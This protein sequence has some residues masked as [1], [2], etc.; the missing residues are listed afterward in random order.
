MVRKNEGRGPNGRGSIYESPKGS[1]VWWAQLPPDD[2][3][4]RPKRRAGSEREA[5]QKLAELEKERAKGID[6][7]EPDETLKQYLNS[8]L[9]LRVK[10]KV[11][12]STFET[13][14]WLAEHYIIPLIGGIR[15][16][17]LKAD[18]IQKLLNDLLEQGRARGTV[19]QV[20][21]FLI[22]ALNTA[23]TT[24]RPITTNP[25]KATA[26]AATDDDDEGDLQ[27]FTENEANRLLAAVLGHRLYLLYLLAL[28][29]GL[30]Q[31]E[32]IGLR[33]S[34]VDLQKRTIQIRSQIH[35]RKRQIRR[36]APKGKSRR[37]IVIDA[38]TA[39]LLARHARAQ[40]DERTFVIDHGGEWHDHGLLFPSQCGTPL[41]AHALRA[42]Y[43]KA[44]EQAKLP[45]L[46]FHAL[47][48]TAACLMLENGVPLADVSEILGHSSPAITA[49][50]YLHGS[51]GGK[52]AAAETMA[53]V[54]G[55]AL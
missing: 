15:L 20:R 27:R 52:Q 34:D 45:A 53:R 30:R 16:R 40:Q 8:Y 24:G 46:T 1:G 9:E 35:R 12:L 26:V 31:A 44:L 38:T 2:F 42:H 7:G 43:Q 39:T 22:A 37:T 14:Q 3:G 17:K 13:Q 25:A 33:W 28:R 21:K 10:P 19:R 50:Y 29:Y 18:H 4:K 23:I 6:P 51:D 41:F 54:L 32:L 36:T 48:H 49:K 11:K 5:V 55:G 47:R